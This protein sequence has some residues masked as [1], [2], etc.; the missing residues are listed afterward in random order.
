MGTAHVATIHW[1]QHTV[2]RKQFCF[3]VFTIPACAPNKAPLLVEVKDKTQVEEGPYIESSNRS[4]RSKR[5]YPETG[6]VIARDI[7]LALTSFG[8]GMTFSCHPGIW[9]V[10]ESMPL[11]HDEDVLDD[12]GRRLFS[13]GEQQKDADGTGLWREASA[14]ERDSMWKEDLEANRQ[15]DAA[16]AEYLIAAA[17]SMEEKKWATWIMPVTRAAAAH[18]GITTE[19]NS[20]AGALEREACMHCGEMVIRG[21]A[22][23]RFCHKVLN[24]LKAALNQEK[25]KGMELRAKRIPPPETPAATPASVAA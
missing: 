8:T 17:N 14:E 20:R 1:W 10:R 15:A 12:G 25:L 4:Q 9:V 13:R 23:C 7:V 18:Y 2:D 21:V 16:Y 6:Q 11:L 19:W 24:P 22:E 5:R 3:G